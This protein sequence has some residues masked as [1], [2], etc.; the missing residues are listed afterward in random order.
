MI[1]SGESNP[2]GA[3]LR[4]PTILIVEDEPLLR[5]ALSDFLQDCGYSDYGVSSAEDAME[6]LGSTAF[7]VDVVFTDVHLNE[8]FGL[9][10]WL[11]ANRP[12]TAVLSTTG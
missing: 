2:S 11:R 10:K 1:T 4:A 3:T 6:V 7:S 9:S 12:K 8:G 5:I